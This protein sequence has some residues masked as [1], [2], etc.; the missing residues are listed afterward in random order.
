V[1]VI[2]P[3]APVVAR[4]EIE[5]DASPR[6]VW[7]VLADIAEWPTWNPVVRSATAPGEL[8]AGAT[9]RRAAGQGTISAR[10][11]EVDAP[12]ALAWR[13]R[14]LGLRSVHA[15][16]IE[17]RSTGCSVTIEACLSGIPA[18]LLAGRL[19]RSTQQQLE[20]WVRLLKLEAE[21]R[22]ADAGETGVGE[23]GP[24]GSP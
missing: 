13:D 9:F 11:L 1:T 24:A 16:T 6:Q 4:A 20:A 2:D 23:T 19:R 15:W 7:S 14:S 12:R 10:L 18:R 17:K 21:T 8:E 5:V 22:A 3:R